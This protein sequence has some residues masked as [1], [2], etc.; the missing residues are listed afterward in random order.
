IQ[1]SEPRVV[2]SVVPVPPAA[3]NVSNHAKQLALLGSEIAVP[4]LADAYDVPV[5]SSAPP[6]DSLEKNVVADVE[7]SASSTGGIHPALGLGDSQTGSA[8]RR[9]DPGAVHTRSIRQTRQVDSTRLEPSPGAL[10]EH[11]K[12]PL[13][14]TSEPSADTKEGP[15]VV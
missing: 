11:F 5:S 9:F 4:D 10:A 7:W 8:S 1:L 14:R 2:R 3:R 13:E 6:K 12:P 15:R